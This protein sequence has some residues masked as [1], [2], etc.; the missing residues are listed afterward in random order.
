MG[1]KCTKIA[2]IMQ[3]GYICDMISRAEILKTLRGLKK[4]LAGYG[5]SKIGLFGSSARG[6]AGA[7]SD[8]DILVD[9]ESEAETYQNFM[10]T[11]DLLESRLSGQ[12]LDIVTVGGLSPYIGP[13]I[14]KEVVYV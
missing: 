1:E 4:A 9:F 2:D 8:I 11:C 10:A 13:H 5:V 3:N 14:L 12:K 6:E 7:D